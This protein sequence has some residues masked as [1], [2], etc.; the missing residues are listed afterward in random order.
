MLRTN[1]LKYFFILIIL[2]S[3]GTAFSQT[4]VVFHDDFSTKN[5]IWGMYKKNNQGSRISNGKYALS[6]TAD[7]ALR[8]YGAQIFINYKKNF[9]YTAKMRQKSGATNQGYGIMWGSKGWENSYYFIVTSSGYYNIGQY[10]HSKYY[11][12][13]AWEKASSI[14]GKGYFNELK[15]EKIDGNVVF[16]INGTAVHSDRFKPFYGQMQGFYLQSDLQVEVD[17]ITL[18]NDLPAM[19]IA[20]VNFKGV[21]RN[22]GTN[23]NTS[24]TEIA[25]IISPDGNTLYFARGYDHNNAGGRSDEADIWYSE[26]QPD[27]TWG[28]AENIGYPL[29]NDGIN[30]VINAMPDG[31]TL[32][33]EG[34]YNSDGSFKSDLGISVT[35]R[36]ANGWS[37]PRKVR[38]DNYVNYNQY[39]TY[40]FTADQSVLI[41]SVERDDTYG[42]LDL[43]VSFRRPNGSYTEPKN[44]G[45]TLNTFGDEGTPFM[46]PDGV[47]L[48]FSTSGLRGFGSDDIYMTTRL[49]DTW[50]RWSKPKNLGS[51]I[52]T[53]DW[54]TYFSLSARGDTAFLVST[55]ASYGWEDIFTIELS[56]QMQPD[57]VVII[58]GKVLDKDTKR[59]VS[60]SISYQDISTGREVGI[61]QSDP[62]TGEYK[63]VLPYGKF[64]SFR[65]TANNYI[66]QS[67]NIDLRNI[68]DYQEIT[69]N[70]YL[71]KLKVGEAIVLN[72]VFFG[73][74]KSDL[75]SSS[76]PELDRIVKI[77]KDNPTMQVELSGHTD[78]RGN[79][80]LLLQLSQQRVDN[81]KKYV[82]SK[83][84][85]ESRI[86]TK[87][88]G[89]TKPININDSE[90]EH[91]KN[92]R[93]EFKILKM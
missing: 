29:N 21:K 38:V 1:I 84:I 54:D 78:N 76:Y 85:A 3:Y 72:N 5:S 31:N 63:I 45:A 88:Y 64:Y 19:Q 62:A 47:T 46:S 44:M 73:Q 18:T 58:S 92:R 74:G 49:D 71:S 9:S 57:P 32:F 70:L 26:K 34:L 60:A 22:I 51:S 75:L 25:P 82:V 80:Q 2:F 27:G 59:P 40:F 66:A 89:G 65:A 28:Q 6:S 24:V 20:D 36:T 43:Y 52:N 12:I 90:T 11:E 41:M 68:S 79:A 13:K 37:V 35:H 93:V 14:K 7:N 53:N 87:A 81:V 86:V 55:H 23:I 56:P 15:I 16:Y 10:Y 33:L 39:E 4:N 91:A 30:V 50:M 69:R 67:E 77:M 8:W 61:A 83:G 42:D 17:E 48:Y